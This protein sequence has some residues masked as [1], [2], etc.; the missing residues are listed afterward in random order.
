MIGERVN[1]QGSRKMKR[2]LLADDYDGVLEVAREQ[3]ESGAHVLDVCVA[4][5]ER[6]DE[7][8]QMRT[9]VKLLS[10]GVE[11]PLCIDTTE[12]DVIRVALKQSPG[13]A[14]VNSI[15]LENGRERC[16]AVLPHVAAHGA[17]VIA[18]TIDPTWAG[19]A[20]RRRP[21]WRSRERSTTSSWTSTA[22][23]PDALIFDALTFTLATGDEEFRRSALET[24]EG[25]R[26]IKRELPGVLTTLG[27]SNVSFGLS[28][29]RA[30]A[31]LNSVFLHHCVQA[32][33]DTAIVNP[34]HVK[35]Y[36][37]IGEEERKLADDLIFDRRTETHDP[38]AAFIEFYEGTSGEVESTVDPTAD[39]G[40]GAGAA[41]EDPAPQE[42]RGRGLDRPRR[43][44]SWAPSP[45]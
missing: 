24:I 28:A 11:A 4:L 39:D 25:I 38:L 14:I 5:T 10:Q 7:D 23:Q 36:V 45:C 20:R 35:P 13:R 1:S 12:A 3:M 26:V 16:D 44:R 22:W 15:N 37:E 2:F 27:V 19:W 43:R 33:L 41:L 32:G 17:A 31:V 42:G 40:A 30:R 8:G 18:L 34:A 29:A 6:Q 9:V 21:S